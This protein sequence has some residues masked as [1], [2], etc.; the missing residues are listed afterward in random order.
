M[1]D[2]ERDFTVKAERD[3]LLQQVQEGLSH[4]REIISQIREFLAQRSKH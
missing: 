1:L 2:R 4:S 3:K